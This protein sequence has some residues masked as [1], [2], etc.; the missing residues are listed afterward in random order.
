MTKRKNKKF[1]F[2]RILVKMG[3]FLGVGLS[4]LILL[5]QRSNHLEYENSLSPR[6]M[7]FENHLKDAKYVQKKYGLFPSV[8]LAQAA[9]ESGFGESE[10]T[11][12][13]HNYFGIK[14]NKD[15]GVQLWTEE[16]MEDQFIGTQDYFRTY[17]SPRQSFDDYGKLLTTLDRY[18]GVANASTPEEA[19]YGLYSAGYSTN[20][21]YGDRIM[22]LIWTYDLT[23]YDHD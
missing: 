21:A 16:V 11:V 3:L 4:L 10:L 12:E 13:Y 6:E 14:G 20:P 18:Q 7:F 5:I 9:L 15:N 8:T 17:R 1:K 2:I 19:A 22:E 23:K